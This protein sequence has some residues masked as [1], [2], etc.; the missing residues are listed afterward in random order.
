MRYG[1]KTS[2]LYINMART[3]GKVLSDDG[4]CLVDT[5]IAVRLS[6]NAMEAFC[7][8][9]G[10]EYMAGLEDIGKIGILMD[11]TGEIMFRFMPD[12]SENMK[13]EVRCI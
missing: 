4:R 1:K 9:V 6:G 8:M 2:A 13:G 10:S 11:E 12:D 5:N 3:H 7:R